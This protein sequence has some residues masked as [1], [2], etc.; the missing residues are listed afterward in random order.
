MKRKEVTK[1]FNEKPQ[2]Q[3]SQAFDIETE[4]PSVLE[5]LEEY[6]YVRIKS[7][8][9][10]DEILHARSLFWDWMESLGTGINR[11]NPNTW[12]DDKWPFTMKGILSEWGIGQ[13]ELMWF[14]RERPLVQKI[15]SMIW[16]TPDLISSFDG[17]GVFR[18]HHLNQKWRTEGGWWH[19]D[20]N[21]FYKKGRKCFQ[22]LV[23]LYDSDEI[24]GSLCVIPS[25]NKK[26][27]DY[28]RK[29][30]ISVGDR[31]GDFIMIPSD[32]M[33][34]YFSYN[35]PAMIGALAGDFIVWDSRT[36]HCNFPG[37][38]MNSSIMNQKEKSNNIDL[39]RLVGYISM[40]PRDLCS[41][42]VLQSRRS[43]VDR[44][45]TT[46]HWANEWKPKKPPRWVKKNTSFK[47]GPK[48]IMNEQRKR[49][50][51]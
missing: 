39:L 42:D 25:S 49:L 6:G 34:K 16:G 38:G 46:S 35:K 30:E 36:V 23:T 5:Y 19:V 11:E 4:F 31:K 40:M 13:S 26:H 14:L 15:F 9:N 8:I 44:N 20:Q 28:F 41:K 29:D 2:Y 24:S 10:H 21:G 7:V 37:T 43:G 33:V 17:L 1:S 3:L 18:P 51:G 50:V 48:A 47:P 45:I 12:D 32:H 27:D 22:G